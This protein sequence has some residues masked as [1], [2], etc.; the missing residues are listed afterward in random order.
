M[1]EYEKFLQDLKDRDI[2]V[3]YELKDCNA[4]VHVKRPI[5]YM[6]IELVQTKC[7]CGCCDRPDNGPCKCFEPGG[8]GRCAYC[9]HSEKCHAPKAG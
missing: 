4:V 2:I 3:D 5:S 7:P 6:R 1:N 9:D 8:N